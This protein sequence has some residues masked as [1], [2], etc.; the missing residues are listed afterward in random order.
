MDANKIGQF[1]KQLRLERNL[2]QYQ[3]ADMIPITRQAVSKWERG[4]SVADSLTLIK[5]SEIFGVTV[6]EI[7]TGERKN[8]DTSDKMKEVTLS[9]VDENISKGKKIRKILIINLVIIV[10]L[11][12][13]FLTYY[14]FNSYNSMKF[15][16]IS[17]ESENFKQSNGILIV[18][19]KKIYFQS[20]KIDY[21]ENIKI[22]EIKL[23]YSLN[24]KDHF[25]YSTKDTNFFIIDYYGYN[26][27]FSYK[28]IDKIIKKLYLEIVYD[29]NKKEKINLNIKNN[30]SN[31][32][33]LFF[34]FSNLLNNVKFKNNAKLLS[35]E[36]INKAEGIIKS[37]IVE[38]KNTNTIKNKNENE[39]IENVFDENKNKK[40]EKVESN[41]KFPEYEK[42]LYYLENKDLLIKM[43]KKN[44][45]LDTSQDGNVYIYN[46]IKNDEK[47]SLNY[48][49]KDKA[50]NIYAKLENRK[51]ECFWL[52]NFNM[53]RLNIFENN[54]V[55]KK[56]YISHDDIV[57]KTENY[58]ILAEIIF[59]YLEI[60]IN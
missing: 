6:D 16:S 45:K 39:N 7:L 58:Q 29:D 44:F 20:G 51:Y 10:L 3:L 34:D 28:D 48:T 43:I 26:S 50:L 22:K 4:V 2:S 33:L 13:L 14:F 46:N 40:E 56:I 35:K 47:I 53:I 8:K 19:K 55:V 27:L 21:N 23:F 24:N 12:L 38:S 36:V 9:I 25:I 17:G 15:Y 18:S 49:E 31:S 1:I 32:N 54:Q 37:K 5:L 60:F 59:K 57:N 41:D 11:A 52:F 30:F 42:I